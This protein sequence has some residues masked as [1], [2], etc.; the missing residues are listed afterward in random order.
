MSTENT[1]FS[2]LFNKNA[3]QLKKTDLKKRSLKL[4]IVEDINDLA[5]SLR[6]SYDVASYYAN[7]RLEELESDYFDAV[8][9]IKLE[10][11]EMAINSAVRFLPEEGEKMQALVGEL[12][13]KSEELGILPSELI[14]GY[15]EI[16]FM[17]DNYQSLYDELISA[18][19]ETIRSTGNNDFL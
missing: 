17:V 12:E 7:G 1:I 10:I 16:T 3:I 2:K 9:D 8:N 19:R 14:Q 15:D 11:D 18:Y 13:N 5:D 6:D 4:S